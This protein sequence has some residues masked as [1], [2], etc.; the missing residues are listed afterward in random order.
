MALVPSALRA[1]RATVF[2]FDGTL[3]DT[4]IDFG[5]MRRRTRDLIEAWGLWDASLE[6]GRYVLEIVQHTAGRIDEPARREQFEAAAAQVL[7]DVEMLSCA[8]AEPF[9][10]TVDALDRL[11]RRGMHI[12]IVT[13]NCRTAVSAVLT[14]HHLHHDVLLTRDDVPRVK[15]DKDHLLLALRLLGVEPQKALMVGDHKTDIECGK[16]AGAWTCGVLTDKTSRDDHLAAGA[17][18]VLDSVAA[19]ADLLCDGDTEIER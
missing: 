5:L 13:R 3:A 19:L 12:G 10:G 9:P 18:L 17:D 6:E 8:T 15:P 11:H 14:R 1:L 16:S 4:R 2:D 7:V